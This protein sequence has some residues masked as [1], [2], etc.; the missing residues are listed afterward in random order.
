MSNTTARR[1]A[2]AVAGLVLLLAPLFVR[3]V[4]LGYNRRPYVPADVPSLSVAAA[5]DPTSVPLPQS[6]AMTGV[7]HDLR[8]GPVVV[9]SG[10]RQQRGAAASLNRLAAALANFGVG[11]RFW[12]SDIDPMT[13]TNFMDYP[14]Q[15][16]ELAIAIAGR[17]RAGG[18]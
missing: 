7:V 16:E 4:F 13:V 17:E 18:G 8:P 14:D 11:T 1:L 3:T 5:P 6:T 12:M 2:F 15:S 9:D 10:P